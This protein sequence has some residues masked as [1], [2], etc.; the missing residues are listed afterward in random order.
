[1]IQRHFRV[2]GKKIGEVLPS[3]RGRFNDHQDSPTSYAAGNPRTAVMEVSYHLGLPINPAGFVL[4]AVRLD[5]LTL[6]DLTSAAECAE[7]G[8]SLAELG[9]DPP[10][11]GCLKVARRLRNAKTVVHGFVYPSV[12]DRPDGVCVVLF[13]E[14]ARDL[15]AVEPAE[16]DLV[17]VVLALREQELSSGQRRSI[18]RDAEGKGGP[19]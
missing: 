12:R 4:W 7:W 17:D 14:H 2:V 1:V 8:T 16:E 6:V 19:T 9:E 3:R 11:P 5:R 15:I 18:K 13:L 10:S